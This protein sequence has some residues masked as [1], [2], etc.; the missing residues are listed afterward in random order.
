MTT[1]VR[2]PTLGESVTEATV[3]TWFKKPGDAVA[4]DEMLCELETDKVTVEVP[5]PA[6]GTMGEIVA[7]EGATVEP[8][9][10]RRR[11]HFWQDPHQPQ[12]LYRRRNDGTFTSHARMTADYD[13]IPTAANVEL[14]ARAV[15]VDIT[16]YYHGTWGITRTY[17]KFSVPPVPPTEAP[18]TLLDCIHN[19]PPWEQPLL[20]HLELLDGLT[21]TDLFDMIQSETLYICSDGSKEKHRASFAWCDDLGN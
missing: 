5:S 17:R 10:L 4:V 15:P 9:A 19:L 11:Y 20:Q 16:P 6:A 18:T 14:P 8:D 2:V 21:E 3:A 13:Q 1:D 12:W 7:A